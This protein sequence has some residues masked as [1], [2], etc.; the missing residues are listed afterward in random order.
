MRIK[1]V[2]ESNQSAFVIFNSAEYTFDR[3]NIL[4]IETEDTFADIIVKKSTPS[5]VHINILDLLLGMLIG[6]G[7]VT[8]VNCDYSFRIECDD[9]CQIILKEN[10]L[11]P[12]EQFVYSSFCAVSDSAEISDENYS[13]NNYKKIRRKHTFIHLFLLSALPLEVLLVLFFLIFTDNYL[14]MVVPVLLIFLL[15]TVPSLKQLKVFK[16]RV[17]NEYAN[18][19]LTEQCTVLRSSDSSSAIPNESKFDNFIVRILN[20]M[21]K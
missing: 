18:Q 21:F 4:Y 10:R 15:F 5:S 2:N 9:N 19:I 1:I 16:Y 17:N 11:S 6:N 8:S 7:S 13:V 14:T 12:K 20:K 3:S